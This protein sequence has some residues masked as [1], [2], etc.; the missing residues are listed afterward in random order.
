[1]LHEGSETMNECLIKSKRR[2]QKHG[3]VFTPRRIV[4]MMLNIPEIKAAC[5][6][7]TATFLEPAAGEGA[8][9]VAILERKLNIVKEKYNL[10]LNQFEN[11]SLLALST[12]YGI[13][14]LEDNAQ[15]C[16]MN[17][18]EL[19]YDYYREQARFH[20]GKVKKNVLAS[21]KEIISSNIAQGDFLK[22][23]DGKG[24]PIVFSEW[25]P[26]HLR[27]NSK[28]IKVQRTE[29]TLEEIY[30]NVKKDSGLSVNR[31]GQKFQQLNIFDILE[32]EMHFEEPK[33]MRY[34]IVPITEVYKAE[35]EEM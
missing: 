10:D 13:E 32:I 19:Y 28:N 22:R 20:N 7:L 12:L 5:E 16:V 9:L 35:M 24:N 15:T 29:Y 4:E 26:I 23:K 21:A 14:L 2:V 11:F 18:Y 30:Q 1:M 33:S 3:E 27:K 34:T 8:F 25:K 6:D 17:M 31:N